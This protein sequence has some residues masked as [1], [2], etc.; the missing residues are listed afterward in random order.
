MGGAQSKAQDLFPAIWSREVHLN[1]HR[2]NETILVVDDEESMRSIM[3][4]FLT[5]LG[6]HTL[7]APDGREALQLAEQ[8]SGKIDLLLTDVKMGGLS[9]PELA[10]ALLKKRPEAKVIFISGYP[11]ESLAPNGVLRPGIV[12]LQKPFT[13]KLL[14]AKLREVLGPLPVSS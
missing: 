8:H 6:Y 4:D 2:G 11:E 13:M 9:G 3:T 1:Y 5:Q 12:L 10:E 14:S 7:S